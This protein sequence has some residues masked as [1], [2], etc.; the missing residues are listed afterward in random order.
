MV[1]LS[2]THYFRSYLPENTANYTTIHSAFDRLGQ[3]FPLDVDH[4]KIPFEQD[5][6]IYQRTKVSRYNIIYLRGLS[7]NKLSYFFVFHFWH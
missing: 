7:K 3:Y 5:I 1:L 4:N 6:T 2:K